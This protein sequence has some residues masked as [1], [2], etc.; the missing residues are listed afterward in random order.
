MKKWIIYTII[1]GIILILSS[2]SIYYYSQIQKRT[3]SNQ[4]QVIEKA[5]N[6]YNQSLQKGMNFSSQCLGTIYVQEIGYA[7][8]IVHIPRISEDNLPQN[9]CQDYLKDKVSH[10]VELDYK[11]NII[12]IL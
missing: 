9:Q 3:L 5:K 10:F 6:I 4:N 11:G 8:D 1:L 2:G 7:V 12:R